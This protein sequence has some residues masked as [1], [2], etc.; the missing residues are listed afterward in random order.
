MYIP[1]SD[2]TK[3]PFYCEEN[4]QKSVEKYIHPTTTQPQ[5]IIEKFGSNKPCTKN[6]KLF[7]GGGGILLLIAVAVGGYFFLYKKNG[8]SGSDGST[9]TPE[10]VATPA[11]FRFY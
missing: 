5:N 2:G 4:S 6:Q 9:A 11:G 1:N 10:A 3:Q 7:M 8:Q